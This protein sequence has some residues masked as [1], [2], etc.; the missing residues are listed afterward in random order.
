MYVYICKSKLQPCVFELAELRLSL[1]EKGE[2]RQEERKAKKKK[3]KR[4]FDMA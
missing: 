1:K 4:V 2:R 3:K